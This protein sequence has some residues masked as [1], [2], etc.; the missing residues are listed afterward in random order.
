MKLSQALLQFKLWVQRYFCSTGLM[1]GTLLFFALSM[2]PTLL[3]RA[4][5]IQGV[6]SGFALAVG[7]GIG[8]FGRWLWSYFE[9]PKPEEKVQHITQLIAVVS[10]LMLYRSGAR[11]GCR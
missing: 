9:L 3:P 5:I 4:N 1:V 6:I 11:T 2:T 10:Y 8:V 7:Y